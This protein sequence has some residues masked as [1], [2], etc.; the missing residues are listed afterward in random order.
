MARKL[1]ARQMLRISYDTFTPGGGWEDCLGSVQTTG[2]WFIWGNSGNGKTSATVSLAREIASNL[3]R[4][5]YNS[6]EEG[7]SPTMQHL[8]REWGMDALGAKF[9]VADMSLDELDEELSRPRSAKA[10][11][12]DSFQYMGLSYRAFKAFCQRHSD[13]LLVFVSRADGRRPEGRAAVSA[14]YDAS[15][16]IWVEG[17]RAFSKGRYIG[18]TGEITIWPEGAARYWDGMMTQGQED[19]SL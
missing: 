14:M 2:I 9:K 3:G 1:S 6:R 11:V 5:L 15:L 10:A 19:N 13:K 12:I 18:S 4:V 7:F 17:Y 8:M 16:K